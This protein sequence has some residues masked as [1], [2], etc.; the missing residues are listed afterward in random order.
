[1]SNAELIALEAALKAERELAG[2]DRNCPNK[3][4]QGE[5]APNKAL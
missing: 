3:P 4:A 2:N 5:I 1:M